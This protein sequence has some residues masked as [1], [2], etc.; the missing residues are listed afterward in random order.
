MILKRYGNSFE[1]VDPVFESAAL[2]EIGFRRDAETSIAAAAFVEEHH[3]VAS[4]ELVAE[5]DGPVQDHAEQLLLARLEEKLLTLEA[6]IDADEV[7]V[8]ENEAG[9]DYPKT[10]Q[11]TKNVVVEGENK[12]HFYLHVDPPLRIGVS[13]RPRSVGCFPTTAIWLSP[14]AHARPRS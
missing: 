14:T 2:N 1:S 5:A 13:R 10:R 12:L 9:R 4:H 3:R 8:V 6:N 11:R 7:L